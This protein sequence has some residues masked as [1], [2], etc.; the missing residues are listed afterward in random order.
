MAERM[1]LSLTHEASSPVEVQLSGSLRTDAVNKKPRN[2]FSETVGSLL[3]TVTSMP[4]IPV[5]VHTIMQAVR[6]NV[7]SVAHAV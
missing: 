4:L 6:E 1:I 7:V 2:N 5:P 3:D